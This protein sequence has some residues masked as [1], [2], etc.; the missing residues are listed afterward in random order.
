MRPTQTPEQ[1]ARRFWQ[2]VDQSGGPTSCWLWQGSR[3]SHGYGQVAWKQ[4]PD[5]VTV[6]HRIAWELSHGAVP[7]GLC[8]LHRC[9]NRRCC[10][11][12]HLFLGTLA[13][14]NADMRSKGRARGGNSK[15]RVEE[16]VPWT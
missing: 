13:D 7:E 2:R 14:N 10:N 8:V 12:E 5:R 9:D 15:T 3:G 4:L 6:T 11:P 16:V 1:F